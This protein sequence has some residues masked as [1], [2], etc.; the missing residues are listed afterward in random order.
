MVALDGRAENVALVRE[1]LAGLADEVDFGFALDDVKAAV[2]EA[3]NNVVVHAYEGAP[4]PLEV[5]V[6]LRPPELEVLVRDRGVGIRGDEGEPAAGIGLA[7]IEA[8]TIRSELRENADRGLE[9]AMVFDIPEPEAPAD[10]PDDGTPPATWELGGDG[11]LEVAIAI[12]PAALGPAVLNRI[13]SALA[14]RAGFS[15]D[16]LSDAQLVTDALAAR[17]APVLDGGYLNV[18][19]EVLERTVALRVGHLREGG[20]ASLLAG[21]T[22]GEPGPLI[23]RLTDT[24][25]VSQ[26]GTREMLRLVMR[27][28]RPA[29]NGAA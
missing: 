26:A 20:S 14:A 28:A 11:E 12:T 15:I 19:I 7:V 8:L 6:R 10:R 21:E 4:G 9:V 24:I 25:E 29:A 27:D 13:V 5:E 1:V 18:G 17:V 22:I 16:R 23:E 3:C 2:S